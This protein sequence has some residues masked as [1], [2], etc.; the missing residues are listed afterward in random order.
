[1]GLECSGKGQ[2]RGQDEVLGVRR[3]G[4]AREGVGEEGPDQHCFVVS[5]GG[6]DR[7][8]LDWIVLKEMGRLLLGEALDEVEVIQSPLCHLGWGQEMGTEGP[9][10]E[11]PLAAAEASS[12]QG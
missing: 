9:L 3:T 10:P 2:S 11:A 6:G 4:A 1:M 12:E 7:V 5:M 8:P